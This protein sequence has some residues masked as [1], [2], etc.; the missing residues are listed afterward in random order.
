[1][2]VHWLIER[3]CPSRSSLDGTQEILDS[4][5]ITDAGISIDAVDTRGDESDLEDRVDVTLP[6]ASKGDL[7]K[8]RYRAEARTKAVRFS[9]TGRS[10]AAA[11]TEGLLIYSLDDTL[12]FDPFD[13]SIDITPQS[14]LDTLADH[15]YLLALI[16]AFRLNEKPLIRRAYEAVP[17]TDVRLIASQ[18]PKVYVPA[19]LRFIATH[20]ESSPHVEF[21]LIWVGAI[22]TSHG[23]WLREQSGA[24]ASDF[25]AIQ[26]GVADFSQTIAR[27]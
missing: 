17:P 16:V 8:R 21:D 2:S 22:L 27:L 13:L 5:K 25:R 1:M 12:A 20:V 24:F 3:L 9:P 15:E 7:S 19:L 4:R 6:G 26:K 11:S 14:V 18:L 23:R 10:W